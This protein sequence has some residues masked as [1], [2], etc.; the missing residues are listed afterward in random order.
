MGS[1]ARQRGRY[2]LLDRRLVARVENATLRVCQ[3]EKDVRN[4]LFGEDQPWEVRYDN[5][6]PNVRRDPSSGLYQCW[7]SPFIVDDAVS[8]TPVADRSKTTYAPERREMGV[9][10]AESRDGIT[11]TKPDLGLMEFE[12]SKNSNLV[13]RGPHGA[14]VCFDPRDTE[15]GRRYKMFYADRDISGAFS[16][17][18][19]RWSEAVRFAEIEAEGDTHNNAIWVSSLGKYVGITRLW[20]RRSGQRLVARTES[21]DFMNWSKAVEV[22][23]ADP[24][25]PESQTVEVMRADPRSPESQTYSM[26]IFEHGGV[27]LGLVAIFHVPTDTVQI[28]LAWSPDTVRW[29]R[30]DAGS[31]VIARG[32]AG[33][34][35]SG[36]AS[37]PGGRAGQRLRL[38]RRARLRG[39]RNPPLLWRQQRP[40]YRL[41]RWVLV[42]RPAAARRIRGL[43][44]LLG[45]R[46]RCRGDTPGESGLR[47]SPGQ[48]RCTRRSAAG[49]RLRIRRRLRPALPR[50]GRANPSRCSLRSLPLEEREPPRSG[51]KGSTARL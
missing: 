43:P 47:R 3:A 4:P 9:C 10:Y 49:G 11:W 28:E 24:R 6:Y 25:S 26:P 22:M 5:L 18:G 7:Y 8:S 36:C 34:P 51:G 20:D 42:P 48:R 12:G 13:A 31:P 32:P 23:R 30:I 2:L 40:A 17:D 33:A 44:S 38:R 35:D 21:S 50:S 16:P 39:R 14:G 1:P 41:A 27:F 37:G 29:E 15:A 45:R 46:A 19:K